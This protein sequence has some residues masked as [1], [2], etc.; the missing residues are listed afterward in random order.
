MMKG[1]QGLTPFLFD[2]RSRIWKPAAS[3]A[4]HTSQC[5]RSSAVPS[6][7]FMETP[8]TVLS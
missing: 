4:L 1:M 8:Q 5:T 3:L 7:L 2:T 6:M